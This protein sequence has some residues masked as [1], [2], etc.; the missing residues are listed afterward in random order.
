MSE[1]KLE[2]LS[3]GER[4]GPAAKPWEGEGLDHRPSLLQRLAAAKPIPEPVAL[5]VAH[6]DDEL[7][8][9]G[10]R[11]HLFERLTLI[12]L[13]DGAPLDMADARRA[14]FAT[15]EAYIEAREDE[16]TLGLLIAGINPARH[17][18]LSIPDQT[19][20][21]RLSDALRWLERELPG[22]A[23]VL[24]HA[25]EGGHPDHDAAAL[26]VSLACARIE[27][28]PTRYEFAGYCRSG[29]LRRVNSFHPDAD[30]PETSVALTVDE[31]ALKIEAYAGHATQAQTLAHLPPEREA[32]RLAPAYDFTR[33]PPP[34]EA[35]YDGYGWALTSAVWRAKAAAFLADGA[36]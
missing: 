36:S 34:G 24:T 2:H 1:T 3:P 22:Q 13:T 17:L 29:G 5:V 33:P 7:V 18:A 20:I 16:V 19:L 9:L 8:G 32:W 28:P 35:L 30:R 23:A 21:D 14:G 26:A 10:S 31:R 6:P 11:L 12:H 25:Y 15:R 27:E 4:E